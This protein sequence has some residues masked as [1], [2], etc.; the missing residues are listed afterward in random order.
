MEMNSTTTTI[1]P[2]YYNAGRSIGNDS[3]YECD[4]EVNTY[5]LSD[6]II[7]GVLINLIG[8]FGILG[9]TISMIILSRPQ[10]KSSINY[11][12]IGLARC[13][14]VLIIVA[15]LIYGLP[16][17]Y[18]YTGLLFHYK[19]IVYPKIIKFL[20]PFSCMA[21]IVTVYLTLTVTVERY[22]AVCH[23]LKARSFC[24]YGRAQVAV[25]VIV[26]F[27]FLYNLPK[28]WEI[29]VYVEIHWK[30]NVTVYCITPTEM[31]SNEYYVTLYIHWLYFFVY[32][33][34]PFIALVIFNTAIYRRV[35]KANKDLQ[36]LSRHQ[37]REIGLATMLL[38]VVVVF[39]I[40]NIL[41]LASNIHETF[42]EDPPR[43][44][45]QIGN[46]LVTINSSINFIIYVIFGRKFKRTFLKLFCSAR[47]HGPN[48]DSPEFQTYD[49]SIVTNTTNI[50]LRNSVRQLGHLNR[51][52][53]INR[54]NNLIHGNV[55]VSNGS[56]RQSI[57][58]SRP[59]SS[60]PCVYYPTKSPA[61]SPSQMSRASSGQNGWNSKKE[62]DDSTL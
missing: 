53:T 1:I 14:T 62:N 17:I 22:I 46:L 19:F 32:Y 55:H 8:L 18:T 4:Q 10:M 16:A 15:M 56:T 35:R 2:G 36:Q 26:V 54:N 40:C 43:W 48:R 6:F 34:F 47:L 51:S 5:G 42:I 58:L 41:P 21:Q 27:A 13:D 61:R 11:L 49:E 37:R 20:Y 31:R 52:N 9:N 50:E 59:A 28:F 12:L 38:C 7:Y 60:G 25:L 57:K 39:L 29:E 45:V 33:M 3:P 44:M 23:P 24:T 30:Y